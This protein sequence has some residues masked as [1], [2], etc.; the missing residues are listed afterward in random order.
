MYEIT[1][2]CILESPGTCFNAEHIIIGTGWN[3]HVAYRNFMEMNKIVEEK[4]IWRDKAIIFSKCDNCGKK[5][6]IDNGFWYTITKDRVTKTACS[7]LC[8]QSLKTEGS[9][10]FRTYPP[11]KGKVE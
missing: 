6:V 7:E 11:L 10:C 9:I 3:I 1:Q 5:N 4:I 2:K 8:T